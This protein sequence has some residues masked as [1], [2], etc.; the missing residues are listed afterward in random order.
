MTLP[1]PTAVMIP[2]PAWG[3]KLLHSRRILTGVRSPKHIERRRSQTEEEYREIEKILI[4]SFYL[5]DQARE[6]RRY[7][8]EESNLQNRVE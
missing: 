6:G 5:C 8:G 3:C 1:T 4:L 2:Q 7:D